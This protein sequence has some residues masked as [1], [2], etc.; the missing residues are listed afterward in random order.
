MA[1]ETEP[2]KPFSLR[3]GNATEGRLQAQAARAGIP[4]RTLAQRYIEESL[5]MDEHPLVHF[6]DGPTGRRA[7]LLGTGAD[8]WEVVA[9]VLDNG[10]DEREAAEY[11]GMSTGLVQAAVTYYGAHSDEIDSL[12][13]RNRSEADESEARWKAGREAI[14]G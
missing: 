6:A 14:S 11:L 9:T 7:R 13:E 5:R 12:I 3:M 1:G 8:V 10:G 2:T 4:A